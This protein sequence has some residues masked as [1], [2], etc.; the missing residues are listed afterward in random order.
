MKKNYE[1]PGYEVK[2]F[3]KF[4]NVFTTCDRDILTGKKS[5]NKGFCQ[6][7]KSSKKGYNSNWGG[8][9]GS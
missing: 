8:T 1:T 2:A 3:A 7:N 6:Q 4:E 9:P 5:S